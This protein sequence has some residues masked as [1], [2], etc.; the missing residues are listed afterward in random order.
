MQSAGSAV[1]C[2]QCL[3]SLLFNRS[4]TITRP[5]AKVTHRILLSLLF[6]TLL[7]M[8]GGEEEEE[9]EEGK[10]SVDTGYA[11]TPTSAGMVDRD[12]EETEDVERG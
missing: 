2:T 3:P 7:G 9:E 6:V 4:T 1:L 5:F 11:Q 12:E 10:G 8:L